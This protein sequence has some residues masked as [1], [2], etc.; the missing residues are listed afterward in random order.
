M[1]K[2]KGWKK[3]NNRLWRSDLTHKTV[4]IEDYSKTKLFVS[5]KNMYGT[6]VKA[7]DG[8]SS[9]NLAIKKAIKYMRGHPNG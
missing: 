9:M 5:I 1:G 8:L 4:N 7:T 3:I 2:I 6:E